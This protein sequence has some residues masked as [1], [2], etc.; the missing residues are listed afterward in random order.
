MQKYLFVLVLTA[1]LLGIAVCCSPRADRPLPR[2]AVQSPDGSQTQTISIHDANDGNYY[3]FLPSYAEQEQLIVSQTFG[4]HFSV[5]DT[6][7]TEGMNFGNFHSGTPYPFVMDGQQIGAFWICKSANVATMYI[8]TVSGNMKYLHQNKGHRETVSVSLFTDAGTLNYANELSTLNGRGNITW[9]Y[10]KRPYT[11]TLPAEASLL[12]M[13]PATKWVLLANAADETNLNNKLIFDLAKKV[14]FRWTP[15]CHW[16]DL[17]LNGEYNG[18]YLLM[19]KVEVHENRL[20]LAVDA[21]DFLCKIDLEER[22]STMRNPFSTDAGR[23][24]EICEPKILEEGDPTRIETMVQQMEQDIF[25]GDDLRMSTVMDLDS[26]VRRYLLD[27]IFANIDAD[28]A[29]AYF[30]CEDGVLF[31]GPLWD[32]DMTLG[33]YPR[34]QDPQAFVAKNGKKS[35]TLLSPYYG[36]LYQNRSFYT[37]MTELYRT[38]FLP[39]LQQLTEELDGRIDF[40][41]DASQSNSLRWR[42]MYDQLP[43]EVVHTPAALKD[44]LSRRIQFLSSAW[45]ENTAYCTVQFESSPGSAYKSASVEKGKLLESLYINTETVIW[46]DSETGEVFDFSQPVMEDVILTKQM[47]ENTDPD[48]QSSQPGSFSTKDLIITVL[49]AVPLCT[50]M[51][52]AAIDFLQ[53]KN[54]P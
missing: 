36:A 27:E 31:A 3:I 50:V 18:L 2:F 1:A 6:P 12:D 9:E 22:R 34:N 5:N 32:Y 29:S 45:L 16:V 46:V 35:D 30:Y 14:G 13:A 52:L 19:E 21:G 15:D 24:V 43:A 26:W 42:A 25:S 37:R 20:N 23:T 38:E 10:D 53:R 4:Q 7:L 54:E 49:L 41:H 39:A 33:N 51:G 44:Y 47:A 48:H 17:Y 28:L 11:L 40:L 8:D